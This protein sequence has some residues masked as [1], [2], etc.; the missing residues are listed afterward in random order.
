MAHLLLFLLASFEG[1]LAVAGR[2]LPQPVKRS[3]QQ[4]K[5]TDSEQIAAFALENQRKTK[6]RRVERQEPQLRTWE[7]NTTDERFRRKAPI[8]DRRMVG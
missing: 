3:Q 8:T 2:A 4:V 1:G 5:L 7:L 6:K